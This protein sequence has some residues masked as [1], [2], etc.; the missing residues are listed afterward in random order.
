MRR[1]IL[2]LVLLGPA[3]AGATGAPRAEPVPGGIALVPLAPLS[4]PAPTAKIAGTPAMVVAREGFWTAVVGIDLEAQPGEHVL[5]IV[6]GEG[7][8]AVHRIPVRAKEY[9][10][11]HITLKDRRMVE[12]PAAD[13]E[14]IARER[15]EIERAFRSFRPAAAV[16]PVLDMPVSGRLSSPF[17]LRRFFNG[18][19]RRPHSGIDIA[20]PAGT[21]VRA[22]APGIVHTVG[23]YFFNGRTVFIDHGQGL[24]SMMCHLQAV[25][26]HPGQAVERGAM[27]GRVG[28]TGRATGPHLHWSVS[29]NDARVNPGL[30]LTGPPAA[31][32]TR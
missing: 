13:L 20:A 32:G 16:E 17:G 28:S 19:P 30:L 9:A 24:V 15:R 25:T 12:P 18:A 10:S 26:V 3:I 22:P 29:L 4:R 2:V 7:P 11:Q 23:E 5:E 27:V 14:R 21:P 6:H 8:L 31:P 1:A